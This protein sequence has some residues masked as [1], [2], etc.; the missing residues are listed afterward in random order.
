MA[1]KILILGQ[2]GTG[3]STSIRNLDNQETYIIQLVKKELPFRAWK[4][5][6]NA[7]LKNIAVLKDSVSIQGYLKSISDN[8]P[9]IK[10][11]V[12]DDLQYLMSVEFIER[13]FESGWDKFNEIASNM[14]NLLMFPDDLR[15][16]LT[17][18][19]L[20]HIDTTEQQ[21]K[22][23]TIGKMLDEKIT[24]EGLFSI[25]LKTITVNGEYF[26]ETQNNGS[27]TIKSPMEM[28]LQ[29]EPNDLKIIL[30]KIEEYNN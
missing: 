30:E 1:N 14:F 22:M 6:Y 13:V 19:F 5:K 24:P 25:V 23:K 8:A 20:S 29:K 16:D 4:K 9:H 12:I 2:S 26:F 11:V 21:E 3:K 15:E 10:T 28:L 18:V 17:V 7:D 27:N